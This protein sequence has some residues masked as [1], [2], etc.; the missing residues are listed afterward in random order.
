M[1]NEK[2]A[3]VKDY[4]VEYKLRARRTKLPRTKVNSSLVAADAVRTLYGDD[5]YIYETVFLLLLDRSL[6]TNGYVRLSQ[7]GISGS[8]ID[9]RLVCKYAVDSLSSA[10]ILVHNHPSG[11]LDP[12]R[13]DRSICKEISESLATLGIEVA[14]F[15]ILTADGYL[16]FRDEGYM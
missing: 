8:V 5:I 15:L 12:S 1:K 11:N 13:C 14:D 4:C 2:V 7:G 9:K 3:I 6:T 10:V 16:S